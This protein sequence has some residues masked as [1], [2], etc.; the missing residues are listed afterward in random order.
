MGDIHLIIL[1]LLIYF[2]TYAE[3]ESIYRTRTV[4]YW[5]L[6]TFR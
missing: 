1:R 6:A 3:E 4:L 5:Q 2:D